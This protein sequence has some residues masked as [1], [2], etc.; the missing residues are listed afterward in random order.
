M[1]NITVSD[2]STITVVAG[3][4][5]SGYHNALGWA[6]VNEDGSLGKS[7]ILFADDDTAAGTSYDLGEFA[8]G[9]TIQFFILQD[10]G[11]R[12]SD[13]AH[14]QVADTA[15]GFH[16]AF[17]DLLDA[18]TANSRE[19]SQ[20]SDFN[21]VVFDVLVD[22]TG[23]APEP[24][25][26]PAPSGGGGALGGTILAHDPA[27]VVGTVDVETGA[28][29]SIGPS[30]VALTDMDVTASGS[31][32]GIS[33]DGF[34][35]IDLATGAATLVGAPGVSLNALEVGADGTIY[36][37]G[38]S[39]TSLY[40]VDPATGVAA[41]LLDMGVASAGDIQFKNGIL[42]LAGVDHSLHA[43]DVAGQAVSEVGAF[44][45]AGVYG[46]AL[47]AD[48]DLIGLAG[49]RS[50]S[51]IDLSTGAASPLP[52]TDRSIFG[53]ASPPDESPLV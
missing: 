48:G 40:T 44:G 30:G 17:E 51:L 50:V 5:D 32:V 8:A 31:G 24:V 6:V 22:A 19:L 34:Y 46:L 49:D 47:D 29:T 33:V 38:P 21:D 3:A 7:N 14:A 2:T 12:I 43:I 35:A 37:A 23:G 15:E 41:A 26:E 39:S 27:G 4:T 45:V 36:A 13:D 25:P 9:T 18:P 1:P 52:A 20:D 16:M 28:F 53:A 10:G 42:Y 11:A